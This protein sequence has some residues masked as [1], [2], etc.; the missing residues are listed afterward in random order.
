MSFE[1]L[2]LELQ[3]LIT[4]QY[5]QN[6]KLMLIFIL[7]SFSLIYHFY[8]R[9]YML[10]ETPFLSVQV[11]ISLLNPFSVINL[12]L[13]PLY[14]IFYMS[15]LLDIWSLFSY[16]FA[17]VYGGIILIFLF[18]LVVDVFYFGLG[19]AL[20]KGNVL[21]P[22]RKMRYFLKKFFPKSRFNE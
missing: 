19:Y 22:N 10:N 2:S 12:V 6:S 21:N 4:F 13:S 11:L 16:Y 7:F 15:P 20:V 9:K 1:T 14:F 8:F 3:N 5:E 18:L 17:I